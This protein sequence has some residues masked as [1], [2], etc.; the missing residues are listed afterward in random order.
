MALF[1]ANRAIRHGGYEPGGR[2]PAPTGS[3]M[4]DLEGQ[5]NPT[6]PILNR[7]GRRR[8]GFGR[9]ASKRHFRIGNEGARVVATTDERW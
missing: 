5:L 4:R 8:A 7:E 3:A 9:V 1:A 2:I 6:P